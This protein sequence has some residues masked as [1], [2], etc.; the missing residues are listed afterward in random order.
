MIALLSNKWSAS[1]I[2]LLAGMILPLAFAPYEIRPIA[3]LSPAILFL[4]WQFVPRRFIYLCGLL[5]QLGF[6]ATG[7]HWVYYSIHL[8]GNAVAP[9]A[10]LVTALFV[11][12]LALICSVAGLLYERLSRN[13]T[14]LVSALVFTAVW[15]F[16]E[17]LRGWIFGGF[18]WL[19]IG[20]SQIDTWFSGYAPLFGVYGIGLLVVLCSSLFVALLLDSSLR[21]RWVSGVVIVAVPVAALLAD[22]IDW[23]QDGEKAL[24]IRMV[25]GN[26]K[27]QTKFDRDAL[28]ATLDLYGDLS[29]QAYADKPDIIIW[30]ETAI[31]TY[32]HR[33]ESYLQPLVKVLEEQDIELL[34]GGFNKDQERDNVFNAFRRLTG[35]TQTYRKSHLVPFGEFMPFRFVLDSLAS[36]IEIPMSDLS[37]GPAIQPPLDVAGEKLGISICYEDVFGEEMRFQLPAATVLVNVSNDTWFGDS[38]APHQHQ[39]IAAMRAREFSR[40]LVRVTNTGISAFISARGEVLETIPQFQQGILDREVMPRHGQTPYVRLG[41]YPVIISFLLVFLWAGSIRRLELFKRP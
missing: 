24:N 30:P 18:P 40:P 11:V 16:V 29:L 33:V 3:F 28:T 23:A 2:A 8:F 4:L 14:V 13:S 36:L 10:V 34:T 6:F 22:Y 12:G 35:E 5:F 32:F 17:W 25:Q 39:E 19:A 37:A 1:L 27:Q 7:V 26:I 21:S 38:A 41:N 15:A 31:P 9:L 20:Y